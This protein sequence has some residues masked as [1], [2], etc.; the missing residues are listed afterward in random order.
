MCTKESINEMFQ[1]YSDINDSI[2]AALEEYRKSITAITDKLISAVEEQDISTETP[3]EEP[4]KKYYFGRY[5]KTKQSTETAGTLISFEKEPFDFAD[6]EECCIEVVVTKI[7][8]NRS[9][10]NHSAVVRETVCHEFRALEDMDSWLD[11]SYDEISCDD[12]IATV[13]Q[14]TESIYTSPVFDFLQY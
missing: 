12:F 9:F 6:D 4:P 1:K 2:V 5:Y 13:S 14:A 3:A 8:Y 11:S 7:M 10:K